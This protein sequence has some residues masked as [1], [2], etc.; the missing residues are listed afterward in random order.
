VSAEPT[1]MT[2][3]RAM[4]L[5]SMSLT[6]ASEKLDV[7]YMT[8]YKY[9]RTGRL[10]A[11]KSRGQWW[12]T[13]EAL[14]AFTSEQ[15]VRASKADIAKTDTAKDTAKT[16][17]TKPKVSR[18]RYAQ[19]LRRRAVNGDD[20]GAWTVITEALASGA[21]PAEIHIDV[22]GAAMT[23]IGERWSAGTLTIS[24]E[25]QATAVV[26]RILGRMTPMFRHPGRRSVT[27]VLGLVSGDPHGL[28]A[29]LMSDLLSGSL[30][31]VVN[32]GANTPAAAFIE[33]VGGIDGPVAVGLLA[34]LD[35]LEDKLVEAVAAINE[36]HP[37]VPI[38]VGGRLASSV[39]SMPGVAGTSTSP[40]EALE[41]FETFRSK[42]IVKST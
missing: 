27:V 7:H 23:E 42:V 1:A 38:Y 15:H 19:N 14:E 24:Q 11:T 32:L 5:A 22:I 41:H 12:V 35:G 30:F 28:A 36:G 2:E 21:T 39:A 8:A 17:R 6:E 40:E 25:H 31:H 20:A 10:H 29:A 37:T 34:T 4:T 3:P 26:Q 18:R 13:D 33:T 9:V 16:S